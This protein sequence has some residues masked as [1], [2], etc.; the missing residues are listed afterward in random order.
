MSRLPAVVFLLLVAAYLMWSGWMAIQ[1]GG[2]DIR[3]RKAAGSTPNSTVDLD[4]PPSL[5]VSLTLGDQTWDLRIG[6]R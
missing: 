5:L 3:E 4:R 2:L 6:A 1:G